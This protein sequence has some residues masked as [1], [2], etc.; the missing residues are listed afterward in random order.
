MG[1]GTHVCGIV[2]ATANNG[3]GVA[4]ASYNAKVL[5]IGVQRRHAQ[6]VTFLPCARMSDEKRR[7]A[8]GGADQSAP[9]FFN[10]P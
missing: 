1:H 10:M 2:A 9:L 5:P 7:N 3:L 4:G 6:A 8:V